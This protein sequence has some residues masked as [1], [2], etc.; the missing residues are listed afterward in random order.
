MKRIE[1]D[2][3]STVLTA[4][5]DPAARYIGPIAPV[6]LQVAGHA[7]ARQLLIDIELI[8]FGVSPALSDDSGSYRPA[9]RLQGQ[10][11]STAWIP[12]SSWPPVSQP[13][14]TIEAAITDVAEASAV[15]LA[16]QLTLTQP[17]IQI[18]E[19]TAW[20]KYL[21]PGPAREADHGNIVDGTTLTDK[22]CDALNDWLTET[23]P[24]STVEATGETACHGSVGHFGP[25]EPYVLERS[26]QA[27]LAVDATLLGRADDS[28]NT[29]SE[30][31][32]Q[33]F[34][35]GERFGTWVL[36]RQRTQILKPPHKD[37]PA[38]KQVT[39]EVVI[40]PTAD[41]LIQQCDLTPTE[42]RLFEQVGILPPATLWP[43]QG[44]ATP[45]EATPDINT[46]ITSDGTASAP[47]TALDLSGVP[48]RPRKHLQAITQL[49]EQ[50]KLDA[51]DTDLLLKTAR[52]LSKAKTQGK[53][54]TKTAARTVIRR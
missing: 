21:P 2:V 41:A 31:T 3:D 18:K 46:V 10:L 35:Y 30:P 47:S 1:L 37:A 50:G 49:A 52:Q 17:P 42:K 22:L 12:S 54:V 8:V 23:F 40:A 6:K 13:D 4:S 43:A 15:D 24:V 27:D 19:D 9:W 11:A 39:S 29:G 45:Q 34:L 51:T 44:I 7:Q 32:T 38:P 26:G 5:F 33:L 14:E 53:P 48:D 16:Y 36:H 28:P 20:L 25:V